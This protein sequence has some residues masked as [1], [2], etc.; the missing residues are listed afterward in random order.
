[1][2][3][4]ESLSHKRCIIKNKKDGKLSAYTSSSNKNTESI[5]IRYTALRKR[6]RW[7]A[8]CS[9]DFSR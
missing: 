5:F 7:F 2:T 1:E 4:Q 8:F 9:C 3:K 6:K